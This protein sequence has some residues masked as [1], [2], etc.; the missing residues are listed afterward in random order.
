M[1]WRAEGCSAAADVIFQAGGLSSYFFPFVYLWLDLFFG[2]RSALYIMVA[3][4]GQ[5]MWC[6]CCRGW[7]Q[8]VDTEVHIKG[9]D[10]QFSAST[11]REWDLESN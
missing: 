7:P 2:A 6:S 3:G 11:K 1:S 4:L 9:G 10:E 5:L 8:C